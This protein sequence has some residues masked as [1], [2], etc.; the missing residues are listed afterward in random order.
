MKDFTKIFSNYIGLEYNDNLADIIKVHRLMENNGIKV[1]DTT[2]VKLA[3]YSDNRLFKLDYFISRNGTKISWCPTKSPV[4]K[5][6]ITF[7]P[8]E[9][10]LDNLKPLSEPRTEMPRNWLDHQAQSLKP[11]NTWG[12]MVVSVDPSTVEIATTTTELPGISMTPFT[13]TLRAED[14]MH[15]GSGTIVP[16][17]TSKD[18]LPF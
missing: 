7:R 15:S 9:W 4:K 17:L 10:W 13:V 12:K 6:K 8:V 3:K 14:V 2:E 11:T 1:S 18:D 16:H 5:T